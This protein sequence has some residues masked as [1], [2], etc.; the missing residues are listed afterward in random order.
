[1]TEQKAIEWQNAFKRTYKGNPM[2]NEA[3][4][5]CNMAIF[6]LEKQIPKKPV[7][8]PDK[9]SGLIRF[10]HCPSCG[11]YFGQ[12][13]VHNGILFSKEK[14]CQGEGCGQAL[15]WSEE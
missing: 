3:N 15:D 6:A 2:E 9:Y 11:R 14:Y 5:A 8:H 1:M 10:Y 4:Q 12:S 7:K 13:G